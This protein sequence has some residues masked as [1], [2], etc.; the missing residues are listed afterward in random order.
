MEEILLEWKHSGF[1][2]Q[3]IM[4]YGS[5]E[6]DT[7][8][9]M[10]QTRYE[11]SPDYVETKKRSITEQNIESFETFWQFFTMDECWYKNIPVTMHGS[12]AEI[13]TTTINQIDLSDEELRYPYSLKKWCDLLNIKMTVKR[14]HK[15]RI[16]I[17]EDP[18]IHLQPEKKDS[19]WKH[20][21]RFT[22][23]WYK[24]K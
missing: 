11:L 24:L 22:I 13:I 2:E 3:I 16:R 23:G 20:I 12:L 9:I 15:L 8:L 5:D 14:N 1:H 7:K 10:R 19:F 18:I 21:K 6:G 4:V 17:K